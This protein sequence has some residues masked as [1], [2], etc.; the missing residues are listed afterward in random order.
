MTDERCDTLRGLG[1]FARCCNQ[2]D[3]HEIASGVD[4]VRVAPEIA[5]RQYA[6]V[7]L[8]IKFARELR[9]VRPHVEPEI[10]SGVGH[11]DMD[12]LTQDRR[13]ACE[14]FTI[15]PTVFNNVRFVV[16]RRNAGSEYRWTHGPAL[17]GAVEQ[18]F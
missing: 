18:E 14:F 9:V 5:A 2:G 16:P 1:A 10:E 15:Q 3:A 17:V 6:D 13:G 8:P 11:D 4:V 12:D 7:L